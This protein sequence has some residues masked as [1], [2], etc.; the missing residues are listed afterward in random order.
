MSRLQLLTRNFCVGPRSFLGAPIAGYLLEAFGGP[1]KGI[2]AFRPAILYAGGLSLV[3]AA[4]VT[5]VRLKETREWR[6]I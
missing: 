5:A 3:S 1:G 6:K 4:L 2:D